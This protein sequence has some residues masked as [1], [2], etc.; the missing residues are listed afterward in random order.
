MKNRFLKKMKK[1]QEK[2][3][4]EDQLETYINARITVDTLPRLSVLSSCV[5]FKRTPMKVSEGSNL[6]Q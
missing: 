5:E 2:N 6:E 1:N 3:F 4:Y